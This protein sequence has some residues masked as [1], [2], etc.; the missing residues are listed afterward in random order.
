MN[1]KSLAVRLALVAS[2]LVMLAPAAGAG[3]FPEW[4][5]K[6]GLSIANM[7]GGLEGP[8]HILSFGAGA[9]VRFGLPHGFG[10]QPEVLYV[11]KGV[12][13]GE[14]VDTDA[15]GTVVGT[16]EALIAIDYVEIPALLRWSP[17][18]AGLVHPSFVL[19]PAFS[20]RTRS[21]FKVTGHTNL[22]VDIDQIKNTDVGFAF[23]GGLSLGPGRG[24][25]NVEARYTAG[26]TDVTDRTYADK[27]TNRDLL[28]MVGVAF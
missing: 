13:Y 23:G 14:V 1:L 24:R 19:G 21:R 28:L 10:I 18:T 7:Q 16:S 17:P 8:D 20:F 4:G 11:V 26:L 5:V 6:G 15:S 12:S 9:Y 3:P 27:S 22:T 2:T 25:I